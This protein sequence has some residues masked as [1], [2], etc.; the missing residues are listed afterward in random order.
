MYMFTCVDTWVLKE[1]SQRH[2]W[3]NRR[4]CDHVSRIISEK[5]LAL[6]SNG[7]EL[8][9]PA[10]PETSAYPVFVKW[11]WIFH[12]RKYAAAHVLKVRLSAV[13]LCHE[14]YDKTPPRTLKAVGPWWK[15][16]NWHGSYSLCFHRQTVHGTQC[17]VSR[18]WRDSCCRPVFPSSFQLRNISL[19]IKSNERQEG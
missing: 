10:Q 13:S 8:H 15:L 18:E 16:H 12:K 4:S 3:K 11:T 9:V 6:F 14:W 7:F 19:E 2:W 5:S 17:W 1:S